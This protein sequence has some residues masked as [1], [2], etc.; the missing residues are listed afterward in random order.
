MNSFTNSFSYE[1]TNEAIVFTPPGK[2]A[3]QHFFDSI[4]GFESGSNE[5]VDRPN[6]DRK[7]DSDTKV[8]TVTEPKNP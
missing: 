7:A 6:I 8:T 2:R 3:H 4:K 5:D 1:T